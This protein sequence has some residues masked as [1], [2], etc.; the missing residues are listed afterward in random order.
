MD[1][2]REYED[3]EKADYLTGGQE[4]EGSANSGADARTDGV[5]GR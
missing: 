2:I 3:A 1:L 5:T 4:A